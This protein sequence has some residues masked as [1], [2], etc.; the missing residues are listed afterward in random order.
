MSASGLV[1]VDSAFFVL[2]TSLSC[3][4]YRF[5]DNSFLFSQLSVARVCFFSFIAL[6]R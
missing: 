2:A 3:T 6:L 5:L 1:R 4:T